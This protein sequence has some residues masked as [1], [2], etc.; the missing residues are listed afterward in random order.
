[1]SAALPEPSFHLI[2]SVA[3]AH[4]H[5]QEG[6]VVQLYTDDIFLIEVL[7]GFIGGAIA[8]GDAAVVVATKA[9]HEGLARRLSNQ[10]LDTA[11]AIRQGRYIV[12]DAGETLPKFMVNGSVDEARFIELIGGVLA[13]VRNAV[14]HKDSRIAVFGELVALLWAGGKP[15]EAIRVEQLW[16]DLAREHSFSLLCAYPIT[17][18]NTERH[19]EPL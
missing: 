4:S 7:S 2:P 3:H 13:S 11:K 19:I 12:L 10:G 14:N 18:F 8:M 1:M 15:E 16:N 5:A 6:H 9:H 17:G